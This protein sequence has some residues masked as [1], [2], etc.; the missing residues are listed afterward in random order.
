MG[1]ET[2]LALLLR[3]KGRFVSGEAVSAEAAQRGTTGATLDPP[4]VGS[5]VVVKF[6][7]SIPLGGQVSMTDNLRALPAHSRSRATGTQTV[8]VIAQDKAGTQLEIHEEIL[9]ILR[10][11]GLVPRIRIAARP[12]G[13]GI[14]MTARALSFS[15]AV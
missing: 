15:I 3:E 11:S 14:P 8:S 9:G 6:T 10:G 13:C 12:D 1:K 7:A 4:W 2:V 5:P